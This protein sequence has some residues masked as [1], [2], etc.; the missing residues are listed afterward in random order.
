[1]CLKSY[2][3]LFVSL[4]C[5]RF[6]STEFYYSLVTLFPTYSVTTA[7]KLNN[8]LISSNIYFFIPEFMFPYHEKL[9]LIRISYH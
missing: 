5:G 9:P 8:K 4:I 3:V 2:N 7:A 6:T 1:M